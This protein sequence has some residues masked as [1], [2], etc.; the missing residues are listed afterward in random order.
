M[1]TH[2]GEKSCSRF[3]LGSSEIIKLHYKYV[4]V[5]RRV[6]PISK[7]SNKYNEGKTINILFSVIRSE[8]IREN[9]MNALSAVQLLN[10]WHPH[11]SP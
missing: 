4:F 8:A 7:L 9:K 1:S 6:V 11:H 2:M 3:F 5:G 10:A